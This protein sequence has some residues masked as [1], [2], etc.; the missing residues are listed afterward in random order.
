MTQTSE[1]N[2]LHITDEYFD[3]L[4]A[5]RVQAAF[6]M[7]ADRLIDIASDVNSDFTVTTVVSETGETSYDVEVHRN[8][9]KVRAYVTR[10]IANAYIRNH[11]L[12]DLDK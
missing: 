11:E 9:L 5:D 4:P 1:S 7:I 12:T 8:N 2:I 6:G 10:L 3:L